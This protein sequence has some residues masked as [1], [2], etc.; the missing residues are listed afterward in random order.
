MLLKKI[1]VILGHHLIGNCKFNYITVISYFM[2]F[3]IIR[4][5]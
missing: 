4:F 2:K 3:Q 5:F 1:I